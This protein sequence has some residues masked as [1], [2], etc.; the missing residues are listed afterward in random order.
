MSSAK[1]IDWRLRSN[2]STTLETSFLEFCASLPNLSD[3]R[4]EEF[5]RKSHSVGDET[6]LATILF[7]WEKRRKTN[8]RDE[9]FLASLYNHKYRNKALSELIEIGKKIS[10][11]LSNDEVK[12]ISSITLPRL[13]S[14]C[15]IAL[16]RGRITGSNFKNCCI[17]D[18]KD[19][20]ITT[21]RRAINLTKM[22]G[23]VP[24]IKHKK[25]IIQQ[26]IK[27]LEIIHENFMYMECGLIIAPQNPYFAGS[28]DGLVC[29]ACHGDGCIKTKY[30]KTLQSD[31]SLE[32]MTRKPNNILNRHG[33]Q[34][35]L[36]KTHEFFYQAQLQINLT[37]LK[38]CDFVIWSRQK[39]ISV[40][41]T[42][43]DEFW[44]VAM[45]KA[46]SFHKQVLMP[47]LLAKFFT[48][49]RGLYEN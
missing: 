7:P 29:C 44:E 45:H 5:V 4:V 34:Y 40:R 15:S 1:N 18:I 16:R 13:K 21:I 24:S 48:D 8:L 26:Y 38:Y 6:A 11:N 37:D 33:S 17:T 20:S 49:K 14:K 47:E 2:E 9:L 39:A 43:D 30:L 42:A 10:L 27:E 3:E 12:E 19:P 36:E 25:S 23:D 31:A 46:L 35:S 28:P 41:V 22:F 32:F